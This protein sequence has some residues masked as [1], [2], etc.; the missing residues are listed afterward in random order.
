MKNINNR[1]FVLIIMIFVIALSNSCK[2]EK[3]ATIDLAFMP[4]I[5][6]SANTITA[7]RVIFKITNE[8][9][10][11]QHELLIIKTDG[12]IME[13]PVDSNGRI[14]EKNVNIVASHPPLYTGPDF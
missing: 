12:P 4:F 6:L 1:F 3:I 7:D 10:T 14:M 9:P 5:R 11:N 13:L 8:D 2:S